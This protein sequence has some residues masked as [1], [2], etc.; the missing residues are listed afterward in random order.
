MSSR[1]RVTWP[2]AHPQADTGPGSY[3]AWLASLSDESLALLE[4]INAL[5]TGKGF[6]PWA[7]PLLARLQAESEAAPAR[8]NS[9]RPDTRSAEHRSKLNEATDF[10]DVLKMTWPG[11]DWRTRD[12][13]RT[14]A[15]ALGVEVPE[16]PHPMRRTKRPRPQM[17]RHMQ[18]AGRALH[19]HPPLTAVKDT[20]QH[21]RPAAARL[22]PLT[23]RAP[24]PEPEDDE[25]EPEHPYLAEDNER[26][27]H[28]QGDFSWR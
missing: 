26:N 2:E 27:W 8:P 12:A 16:E 15:S 4:A 7:E 24:E 18:A 6:A 22:E 1:V 25:A 20:C 28:P 19:R 21:P 9:R 10:G 17:Q 3:A 14:I 11:A 13:L 23:T 5:R